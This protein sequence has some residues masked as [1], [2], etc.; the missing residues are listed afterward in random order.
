MSDEIK[1]M[2]SLL[3]KM[4]EQTS[5]DVK[6]NDNQVRAIVEILIPRLVTNFAGMPANMKCSVK[7]DDKGWD[8]RVDR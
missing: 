4:T 5:G 1:N 3:Q 6:L 2:G 7:S 8:I